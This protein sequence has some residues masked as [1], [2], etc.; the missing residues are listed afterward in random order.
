MAMAALTLAVF[1]LNQLSGPEGVTRRFLES[2]QR[3]DFE[4]AFSLT[5]GG[6]REAADWTFSF[7]VPRLVSGATYSIDEVRRLPDAPVA[8]VRVT[9]YYPNARE[10]TDWIVRRERRRWLVDLR[11][12]LM[13]WGRMPVSLGPEFR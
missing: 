6:N 12:T 1:G 5:E 4:R 2:L 8:R 13:L 7:L 10:G 11:A 9:F 3:R